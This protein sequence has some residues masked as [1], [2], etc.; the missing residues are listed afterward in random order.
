MPVRKLISEVRIATTSHDY[1]YF[2]KMFKD[3]N[4]KSMKQEFLNPLITPLQRQATRDLTN[5]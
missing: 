2:A 5:S 1:K 4:K 3:E